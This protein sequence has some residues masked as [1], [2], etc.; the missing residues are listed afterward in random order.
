LLGTF[1]HIK[2]LSGSEFISERPARWWLLAGVF[3]LVVVKEVPVVI[4]LLVVVVNLARLALENERNEQADEDAANDETHN[5]GAIVKE[6][7]EEVVHVKASLG[8][9]P[10]GANSFPHKYILG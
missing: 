3:V 5:A 8:T 6:P 1:F 7:R 9:G 4:A 2:A 10:Q